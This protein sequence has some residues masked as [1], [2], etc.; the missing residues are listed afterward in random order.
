MALHR[1]RS[2]LLPS[3]AQEP[4]QHAQH[5]ASVQGLPGSRG[6]HDRWLL[7]HLNELQVHAVPGLLHQAAPAMRSGCVWEVPCLQLL[8]VMLTQQCMMSISCRHASCR[9]KSADVKLFKK[10]KHGPNM[11]LE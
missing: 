9:C 11:G 5:K 3:S 10:A 2:P 4:T 1:P 7:S 8:G 6:M